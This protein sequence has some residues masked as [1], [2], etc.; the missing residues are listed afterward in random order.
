MIQAG[1]FLENPPL[2]W[3]LRFS[4]GAEAAREGA[5]EIGRRGRV[6]KGK[7]GMKCGKERF[8]GDGGENATPGGISWMDLVG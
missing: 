5:G 2:G 4:F 1:R 3:S 8:A 7:A 6:G